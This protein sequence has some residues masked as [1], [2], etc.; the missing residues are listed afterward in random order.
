MSKLTEAEKQAIIQAVRA[1]DCLPEHFREKLFP[2]QDDKELYWREKSKQSPPPPIRV[3]RRE[4]W[5]SHEENEWSNK[6][7]YGDNLAVLHAL[8]D[9]SLR[10]EIQ[11]KGGI[12][13]I[14]IDPPFD[15]GSDFFMQTPIGDS[16]ESFEQL[17]Y[18]DSWG[19]GE[20]SF[21]SMLYS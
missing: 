9:T 7:I 5:A 15:V 20:T 21:L 17:A 19:P 6:L 18:T 12:K 1:G 11:K 10:E 8:R 4:Q 16:T 3:L 2:L 14:Y 13:L